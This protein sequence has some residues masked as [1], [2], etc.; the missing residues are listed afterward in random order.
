MKEILGSIDRI[1]GELAVIIFDQGGEFIT[2]ISN[3]PK[4]YHEGSV[5]RIQ[6]EL[7]EAEEKKRLDEV[8]KLQEKLLNRTQEKEKK[9]E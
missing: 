6:I 2:H 4:G 9:K 8:Q 3:L 7:D 5:V 1:E